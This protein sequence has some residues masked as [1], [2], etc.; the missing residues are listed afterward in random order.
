MWITINE[1]TK[2]GRSIAYI[3]VSLKYLLEAYIDTSEL[4]HCLDYLRQAV[5]CAGNLTPLTYQYSESR[6][7]RYPVFGAQHTCR[8]FGK[9]HEWAMQRIGN[10][11]L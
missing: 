10:H 2:T 9:I 4:D 7:R 5:Q 6:G 11:T 1:A 3:L 8:D